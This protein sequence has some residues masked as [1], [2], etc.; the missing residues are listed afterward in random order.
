MAVA[1]P[2]GGGEHAKQQALRSEQLSGAL[3]TDDK[4]G[5]TEVHAAA[6]SINL[7]RL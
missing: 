3:Q 4:Q 2:S 1:R 6:S 5:T 7:A